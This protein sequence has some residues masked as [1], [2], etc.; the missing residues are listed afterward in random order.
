MVPA[1]LSKERYCSG[2]YSVNDSVPIEEAY[3]N[4]RLETS[5]E[6]TRSIQE[7]YEFVKDKVVK[8]K[9]DAVSPL[10][11]RL[12]RD[13]RLNFFHP[14]FDEKDKLLSSS[15]LPRQDSSLIQLPK[16]YGKN[17]IPFNEKSSFFRGLISVD[18]SDFYL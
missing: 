3:I 15:K 18:V 4:K 17:T 2:Y 16:E 13:V 12:M 1:H 7:I 11:Q 14:A 8:N 5:V 9:T 6:T 10:F